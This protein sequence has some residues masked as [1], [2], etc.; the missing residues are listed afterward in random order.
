M[1]LYRSARDEH[2]IR[3]VFSQGTIR[4]C[5]YAECRMNTALVEL[6]EITP[7]IV[8][9]DSGIVRRLIEPGEYTKLLSARD[10][11]QE[12]R[13]KDWVRVKKGLYKGDIGTVTD[14][15]AWGVSMLLVPRTCGSVAAAASGKRKATTD[16]PAAKLMDT[17]DI[18][19][20]HG[21]TG[22]SIHHNIHRIG[23]ITIEWGLV[24]KDVDFTSIARGSDSMPLQNF[25]EFLRSGHPFLN[26]T[27]MLRPKEWWFDEGDNVFDTVRKLCGAVTTVGDT[28]FEADFGEHGIHRGDWTSVQKTFIVGENVTITTGKM[29]GMTGWLSAVNGDVATVIVKEIREPDIEVCVMNQDKT[30][31]VCVKS[32]TTPNVWSAY[33]RSRQ[34]YKTRRPVDC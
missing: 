15:H 18:V 10:V 28:F 26:Q 9:T 5:I 22:E 19:A 23:D 33:R 2:D 30:K 29:A 8:R 20:I 7:G 21:R 27:A 3:S 24:K 13:V 11:L 6:M 31:L 17:E 4:G 16:I 32:S 25:R 34:Y 14:V 12:V 1:S